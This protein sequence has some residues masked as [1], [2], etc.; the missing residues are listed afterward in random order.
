VREV[1]PGLETTGLLAMRTEEGAQVTT[2]NVIVNTGPSER[3][4]HRLEAFL[5]CPLLYY[6]KQQAATTAQDGGALATPLARGTIGHTGLAHYYLRLKTMR[7]GKDPKDVVSPR[8]A[9]VYV[10]R[11]LDRLDLLPMVSDAVRE[12]IDHWGIESFEIVDVETPL[13]IRFNGRRYTARADLVIRDRLGTWIVDHKFVGRVQGHTFRRY[14]LSGQFL[15]L[16]HLGRQTYRDFAGVKLNVIGMDGHLSR[17]ELDP[18]PFMLAQFPG[19]VACAEARIEAVE[20]LAKGARNP[21]HV[22]AEHAAPSE[23]TCM[24][25]YGECEM[26]ESCRWGKLR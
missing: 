2:A 23:M 8:E 1:R 19:L 16:H 14:T 6:W 12:Y 26:F 15:G 13:E 20:K 9:M 10:A 24:T 22:W 4:W 17:V 11:S 3:G 21:L 18:A 25:P 5:R 7:A